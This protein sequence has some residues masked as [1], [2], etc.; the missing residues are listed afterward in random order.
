MN[1]LLVSAYFPPM[2]GGIPTLLGTLIHALDAHGVTFYVLTATNHPTP[3]PNCVFLDPSTYSELR[4]LT[5]TYHE[6]P[7]RSWQEHRAAIDFVVQALA[8]EIAPYCIDLIFCHTE[9][10]A[11]SLLAKQLGIP[12][13]PVIHGV[14][15]PEDELRAGGQPVVRH[16]QAIRAGIAGMEC[17][18]VYVSQYTKDW[19]KLLTTNTRGS[20]VIYNP[21]DFTVFRPRDVAACTALREQLHIPDYAKVLCYPQRPDRLGVPLLFACV[22]D[23]IR[24]HPDLYFLVCGCKSKEEVRSFVPSDALLARLRCGY[25]AVDEMPG[26][27]SMSDVVVL[28]ARDGFG[29]PAF[30]ALACGTP[31]VAAQDS[32]FTELLFDNPHIRF[33]ENNNRETLTIALDAALRDRRAAKPHSLLSSATHDLLDPQHVA[34]Q[35]LAVLQQA[36]ELEHK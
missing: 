21:M 16:Y 33:V 18:T 3:Y 26:V 27:Y 32:A 29:Y 15:P 5:Q 35:Y 30:E 11:S 24:R 28:P 17:P 10:Y 9:T 1:I 31:L 19:W 2:A 36:L 23:L 20:R 6:V 22:D 25:F 12:C 14:F 34:R 8:R 4:A 13:V 7:H